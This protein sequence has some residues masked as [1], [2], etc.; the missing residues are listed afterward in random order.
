M[1]IIACFGGRHVIMDSQRPLSAKRSV[2]KTHSG[3]FTLKPPLS[4]ICAA[5]LSKTMFPV[6]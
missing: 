1:V 3:S 4:L 2:G 5:M 6:Y